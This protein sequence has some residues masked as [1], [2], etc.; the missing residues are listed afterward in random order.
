[1]VSV[2]IST[3]IVRHKI[4]HL[5]SALDLQALVPGEIVEEAAAGLERTTYF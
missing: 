5:L 1:M 4:S 2:V 3:L